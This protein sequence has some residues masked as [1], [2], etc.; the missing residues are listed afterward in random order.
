M[1]GITSVDDML[2][3]AKVNADRVMAGKQPGMSKVAQMIAQ[4]EAGGA[5]DSVTLSPVAKLLQKNEGTKPTNDKSYEEQE[6]FI[7]AKISQLRSQIHTYSNVPGL[8]PSGEIMA[9]LEKEVYTLVNK[10]MESLKKTDEAAKEA[11]EKLKKL[12][13]ERAAALP[14][15]DDML[16]RVK[17]AIGGKKVAAFQPTTQATTDKDKA[18][19]DMLKKVGAKVDK[20]V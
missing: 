6:W 1:T 16:S 2:A 15:A 20:T 14:T 13:A 12:E 11:Q 18:V 5:K 9:S 19:E 17:S 8:D 4:M 10:Q 7:N 3:K